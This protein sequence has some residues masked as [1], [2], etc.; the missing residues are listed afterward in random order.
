MRIFNEIHDADEVD[1]LVYEV[2]SM[3][4]ISLVNFVTKYPILNTRF[5][6]DDYRYVLCLRLID[7]PQA[8]AQE[9][10]LDR[11]SI[12][13]AYGGFDNRNFIINVYFNYL[14][15]FVEEHH[16][17]LPL[18][19]APLDEDEVIFE[20]KKIYLFLISQFLFCRSLLSFNYGLPVQMDSEVKRQSLDFLSSI[21][22]LEMI[23]NSRK[24][25]EY[26]LTEHSDLGED[27]TY[28][29]HRNSMDPAIKSGFLMFNLLRNTEIVFPTAMS[30]T[31]MVCGWYTRLDFLAPTPL[32]V[33]S[34]LEGKAPS[35][36][37]QFYML[38]H[39]WVQLY[40]R[41]P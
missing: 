17:N 19:Q 8:V 24:Q 23:V 33:E 27:L 37:G 34:M 36:L 14:R 25:M 31:D 4:N 41:T 12:A 5:N 7:G 22:T 38:F 3:L 9:P 20:N 21:M 15:E 35:R 40:R 10:P 11:H 13:D 29:F 39:D 16:E 32:Y 18:F 28:F 26:L 1:D 2:S 6:I 30:L